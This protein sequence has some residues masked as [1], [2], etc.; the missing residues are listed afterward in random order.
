MTPLECFALM[1]GWIKKVFHL[2]LV[3]VIVF[4]IFVIF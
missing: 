1:Y 4:I 2:E 3:V